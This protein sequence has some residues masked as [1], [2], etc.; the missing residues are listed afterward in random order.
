MPLCFHLESVDGR[1]VVRCHK[2]DLVQFLPMSNHCRRCGADFADPPAPAPEI[3]QEPVEPQR[4]IDM[5]FA[6]RLVRKAK[7]MSQRD[8]AKAIKRPRTWIARIEG[9]HVLSPTIDS[10]FVIADGL[11]FPADLLVDIAVNANPEVQLA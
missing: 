4:A 2:C 7:G 5:A 6:V 8:L 10:V 11:D 3:S 9:R 1:P